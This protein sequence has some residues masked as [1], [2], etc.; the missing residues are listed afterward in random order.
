MTWKASSMLMYYKIRLDRFDGR[1][2]FIMVYYF[3][4]CAYYPYWKIENKL[5]FLAVFSKHFPI[6][7]LAQHNFHFWNHH[8]SMSFHKLLFYQ[9][10]LKN[11]QNVLQTFLLIMPQRK[12][13]WQKPGEIVSTSLLWSHEYNYS[14]STM[15]AWSVGQSTSFHWSAMS[16]CNS[17]PIKWASLDLPDGSFQ[18]SLGSHHKNKIIQILRD[19]PIPDTDAISNREPHATKNLFFFKRVSLEKETALNGASLILC[20]QQ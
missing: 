13:P 14:Q 5:Y 12:I 3:C 4:V 1:L 16:D 17:S 18:N 6:A 20:V 7:Y 11:S 15:K 9:S 19:S 2:Q 8:K 10:I